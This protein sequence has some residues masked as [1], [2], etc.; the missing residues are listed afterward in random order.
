MA[1]ITIT[2]TDNDQPDADGSNITTS[3]EFEPEIRADE[4]GTPAQHFALML[5]TEM[6]KHQ[7][8]EAKVEST[9]ADDEG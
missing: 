6:Q 3:L 1:K 4:K 5:L 9:D 8:G 7:T 2:I